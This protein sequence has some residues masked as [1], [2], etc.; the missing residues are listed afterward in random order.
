MVNFKKIFNDSQILFSPKTINEPFICRCP[1]YWSLDCACWQRQYRLA[2]AEK[3]PCWVFERG[4][5]L[6]QNGIFITL[7]SR[8]KVRIYADEKLT[9]SK[10]RPAT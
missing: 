3:A 8:C 10:K 4:E 9:F 1:I 6:L 7:K 2:Q 5:N